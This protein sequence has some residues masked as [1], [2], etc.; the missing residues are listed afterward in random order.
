M[1][2]V[3]CVCAGCAPGQQARFASSWAKISPCCQYQHPKQAPRRTSRSC[4]RLHSGR[5]ARRQAITIARVCR[6]LLVAAADTK[7]SRPPACAPGLGLRVPAT[8]RLVGGLGPGARARRRRG[9]G[10]APVKLP[11]PP[12][13][14]A[15][16]CARPPP[17]APRACLNARPARA[18]LVTLRL[19]ANCGP[20]SARNAGV[21]WAR[22]H[23]ASVICF[24][25]ADCA[26]APDWTA[27][28][29][30]AQRTRP[31]IVCGRTL[32]SS[33]GTAIGAARG[34]Y[35]VGLGYSVNSQHGAAVRRGL[36]AGARCRCAQRRSLLTRPRSPAC[37]RCSGV[38][39]AN[40][41][42][43]HPVLGA[44]A[45]A[46]QPVPGRVQVLRRGERAVRARRA[47]RGAAARGPVAPR[48]PCLSMQ[49]ACQSRR[50]TRCK[51][52]ARAPSRRHA[53]QHARA[54]DGRRPARRHV[55]R[56]V[57][58]AERAL[59]GRRH[60]AVRLHLQPVHHGR[61]PGLAGVRH[62][63]PGRRL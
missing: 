56:R 39:Q 50:A 9:A 57:R 59:P 41:L 24:L 6:R 25:D 20:A 29:E 21:T 53:W 19:S 51:A 27:T 61:R 3:R 38:A 14:S 46:C 37:L 44:S 4:T 8:L 22:R 36:P 11:P 32:A 58:H 60:A 30:R 35:K 23:G 15:P 28:M 17:P 48:A 10:R 63:L 40:G 33:P 1:C 13:P 34:G 62:G 47:R 45:R 43:L 7:E 2:E 52:G 5:P 26:P 16:R 54:A 55:P 12:G 18:Q 31:G 49:A 42:R